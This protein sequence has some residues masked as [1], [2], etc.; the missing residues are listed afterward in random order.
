MV[1]DE[2]VELLS[3]AGNKTRCSDLVSW[4]ERAGF[5]VKKGKRGNHFTF[6]HDKIN[7]FTTSDF[8]CGHGKNPYVKKPYI[9]KIL[10]HIVKQY[11]SELREYLSK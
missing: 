9:T 11:E 4:L 7:G 3:N 5:K 6:T 2:L 10:N 1:Y 8:N